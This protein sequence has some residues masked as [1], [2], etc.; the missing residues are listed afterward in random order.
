[1][2]SMRESEIRKAKARGGDGG[3]YKVPTW[4]RVYSGMYNIRMALDG[5]RRRSFFAL[6][7]W[8]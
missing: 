7:G 2:M 1:M 5:A 4:A 3:S 8:K 6:E